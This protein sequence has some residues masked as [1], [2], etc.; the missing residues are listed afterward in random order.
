MPDQNLDA[1]LDDADFPFKDVPICLKR[2]ARSRWEVA[3]AE[4]LEM[5][6]LVEGTRDAKGVVQATQGRLAALADLKSRV[7]AL[8]DEMRDATVT[9]HLVGMPFPAYNAVLID[10]PPREGNM[11]DRAVG[12]NVATFYPALVKACIASPVLS[13]EQWEKLVAR[14]TD[15]DFDRLATAASEVNRR[16]DDGR[17]PFSRTASVE[18]LDSVETSSSPGPSE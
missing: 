17:V 15:G 8:E 18:M 14:L 12:Y 7:R 5:T 13:D 11:V 2:S 1:L 6:D 16:L 9:F 10:H 4:L 3:Q